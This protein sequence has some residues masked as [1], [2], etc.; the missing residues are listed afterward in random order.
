MQLKP[1]TDCELGVKN[2]FDTAQNIGGGVR[3]LKKHL[4]RYKGNVKMALAACRYFDE[5]V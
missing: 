5:E 3:F 1:V 4:N 2:S